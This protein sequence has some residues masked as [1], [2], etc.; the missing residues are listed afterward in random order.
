MTE[1]VLVRTDAEPINAR[2]AEAARRV[3]FGQIDGLSEQH[4]RRWRRIWNWLLK[5][6]QPGEMLQIWTHRDRSGPFHRRHF[7]IEQA[8]F[9]AQERFEHFDQYLC[10]IKVGA[11]WVTWVAGPKG[12]IIPIPRSVSYRKADEDEFREFHHRVI[13]FLRGPRAARYLWPHLDAASAAAY[14]E[15]ILAEHGE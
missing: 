13:A 8:V 9:D 2:D 12:G 3:L 14:M 11:G 15:Q 10:W 5:R 7:R 4:R 6:A 1:I